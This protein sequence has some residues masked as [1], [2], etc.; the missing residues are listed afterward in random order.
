MPIRKQAVY[1]S[2]RG[3]TI[4]VCLMITNGKLSNV[5]FTGDFFGEPAEEFQKIGESLT[6]LN[7]S[8]ENEIMRKIDE[9]FKKKD[10]W[11]AGVAPED[12]KQALKKAL[13]NHNHA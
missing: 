5:I 13:K 3:K 4:R 6:G 1:R 12:F 2:E 7:V 10:I 11:V 8:D 9:F